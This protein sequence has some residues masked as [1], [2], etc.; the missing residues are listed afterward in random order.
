M[1]RIFQDDLKRRVTLPDH[2]RRIVCL[3][4]SLTETLF[5]LGAGHRVVGRTHYCVH[6]NPSVQSANT[7]GG[8]KDVNIA[9]VVQL[10]PDLVIA[11]KE[12]NVAEQIQCLA[13]TFPVCVFD[14][15]SIASALESI[16]KLGR[17]S[18]TEVKAQKLASSIEAALSVRHSP[19]QRLR[20]IYLIWQKPYIAAGSRTYINDVLHYAG[21]ENLCHCGESRYPKLNHEQ[22]V[23]HAPDVLFLATEPFPFD[24]SHACHLRDH[25]APARVE[26]I[27]GE[28]MSWYG[29][30]MTKLAPY[31]K[32]LNRLLSL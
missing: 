5:A 11:E 1:P 28:I 7:V 32:Q 23:A 29:V 12:E 27:D 31:L 4:P 25:F 19:T 20:V 10:Q 30:R 8:T 15:E 3:C 24:E 14:V 13:H 2:P 22:I 16:R 17:I 26:I 9:S 18:N 6:P 21:F